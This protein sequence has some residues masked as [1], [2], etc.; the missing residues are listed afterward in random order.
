M[1]KGP[2][3]SY[4]LY[5]DALPVGAAHI[6]SGNEDDD[7]ED[8]NGR[9][10]CSR[11]RGAI[12][13]YHFLVD[14]AVCALLFGLQVTLILVK[15]WLPDAASSVRS[16]AAY[17]VCVPVH[18]SILTQWR[19]ADTTANKTM[20]LGGGAFMLASHVFFL[21]SFFQYMREDDTYIPLM[22]LATVMLVVVYVPWYVWQHWRGKNIVLRRSESQSFYTTE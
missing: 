11:L 13:E 10:C 15:G 12:V 7:A 5:T 6:P 8:K 20:L 2:D 16:F 4:Y 21:M 9:T 19:A 3:D 17:M 1:E 14:Y 18:L 22:I